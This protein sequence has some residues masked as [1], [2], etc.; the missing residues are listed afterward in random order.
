M[1]GMPERLSMQV[2]CKRTAQSPDVCCP[3]CGQGFALVSERQSKAERAEA[4]R[5]AVRVLR[6]HHGQLSSLEAHPE[7]GFL[8]PHGSGSEGFSGGAILGNAPR[9]AL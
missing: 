2:L 1:T 9:W 8:V 4:Q 6:R 7:R 3:V 5:E